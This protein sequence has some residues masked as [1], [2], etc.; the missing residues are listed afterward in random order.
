MASILKVD[1]IVDSGSNVLATSSGSG[2]AVDSGVTI[3]SGTTFPTGHVLQVKYGSNASPGSTAET[4]IYQSTGVSATITPLYDTSKIMVWANLTGIWLAA[5]AQYIKMKVF[6]DSTALTEFAGAAGY[7]ASGGEG[8]ASVS[9]SQLVTPSATGAKT[10]S[11]KVIA[12]GAYTV[13]WNNNSSLST[14]TLMEI[15][16]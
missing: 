5:S 15:S 11:I 10:Y 13:A 1:K 2:Y 7:T 6:E 8:A 9:T 4:S 14:I 3:G 16:V 12:S